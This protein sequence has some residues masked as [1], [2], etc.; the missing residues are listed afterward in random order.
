MIPPITLYIPDPIGTQ[1]KIDRWKGPLPDWVRQ[2]V[3]E[4]QD[5]FKKVDSNG[6]KAKFS[7]LSGRLAR[8]KMD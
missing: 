1:K 8:N 4:S 7:I 5:T 2:V 3:R 6:K